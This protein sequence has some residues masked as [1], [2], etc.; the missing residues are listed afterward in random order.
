MNKIIK[1]TIWRLL[2][3]L[4]F[5][6]P[7]LNA[8]RGSS[9]GGAM[10]GS[11]FGSM[12]GSAMTSQPKTQTVFI[13]EGSGGVSRDEAHRLEKNFDVRLNGLESV[14]RSDL[15]KLNDRLGELESENAKFKAEH[16]KLE[17]EISELRRAIPV[18]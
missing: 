13:R 9:F 17:R 10:A 14:V 8:R 2:V 6:A 5:T 4:L 12:L 1:S 15:N 7:V 11:M 18:K 16:A 3:V